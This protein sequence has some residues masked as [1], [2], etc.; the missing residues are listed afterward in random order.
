MGW[1]S[2]KKKEGKIQ[3]VPK[4]P[5]LPKIDGRE[6][7]LIKNISQ[8]PSFPNNSIGQKFSQNI[9]KE[10]VT[11]KKE[12]E[13]AQKTN[14]FAKKMQMMPEPLE[15]LTESFSVPERMGIPLQRRTRE[16][17]LEYP[18]ITNSKKQETEGALIKR[19]KKSKPVFIKIEKFEESLA[20]FDKIKE[21]I[22]EIDRTLGDI[23]K[24]KK[25][26]EDELGY[27]ESEMKN[28][29]NQLDKIDNNLFSKI[30]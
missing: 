29:K 17:G 6:N 5:E 16:G 27:W 1:F 23:K 30:E 8:L 7:D 12:D 24:V 2:K 3:N 10:A 9:I 15:K 4:F 18:Q 19:T 28:I 11:G 26:E 21:Q 22:T 20:T 13:E 25:D 14:D